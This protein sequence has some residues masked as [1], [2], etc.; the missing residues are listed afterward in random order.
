MLLMIRQKFI[1]L[2]IKEFSLNLCA[3]G[4]NNFALKLCKQEKS[5]EGREVSGVQPGDFHKLINICVEILMAQKYFSSTSALGL[6][7]STRQF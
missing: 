6:P 3:F 4:K 5:V 7:Y 1:V 2:P